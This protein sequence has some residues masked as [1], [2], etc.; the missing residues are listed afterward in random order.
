MTDLTTFTCRELLKL[1]GE[2]LE[3]LRRRGV[4]R[5]SNNPVA[6]YS[7]WLA[8]KSLGWTL[9]GNSSAGFDAT[10]AEGR[11]IQIKGR[12]LTPHNSS[13]QLSQLRKLGDRPFDLLLG[14]VFN[15]DFS[16]AYAGI[17]PIEVVMERSKYTEHT[18]SYIFH[19]K[20][21]L[22]VDQRVTDVTMQLQAT[23]SSED[24]LVALKARST[25]AE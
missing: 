8:T 6:D 19:M 17:V 7:E 16:V 5:S 23:A 12:R 1:H 25:A 15:P 11:K 13:T 18:N 9:R 3:E 20:R 4:L 24:T 22:L 2:L 14:I 21:D 10:D